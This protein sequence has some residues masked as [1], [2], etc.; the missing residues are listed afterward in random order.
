MHA[1]LEKLARAVSWLNDRVTPSTMQRLNRHLVLNHPLL[2]R[3]RLLWVAWWSALL[4]VVLTGVGYWMARST[5]SVWATAD[6][7]RLLGFI[8]YT[9][10]V[11]AITWAVLHLRIP[12]GELPFRRHAGTAV[13]NFLVILLM[14]LPAHALRVAASHGGTHLLTVGEVMEL[15][16]YFAKLE[17]CQSTDETGRQITSTLHRLGLRQR[18]PVERCAKLEVWAAS[19]PLFRHD[20]PEQYVEVP[21]LH[22]SLDPRLRGMVASSSLWHPG[23]EALHEG[24]V[25]PWR[26]ELL[27]AFCAALLLGILG[28]PVSAWRRRIGISVRL[29]GTLAMPM[30]R[31]AW[32]DRL[33]QR[34]LTSSPLIWAARLHYLLPLVASCLAVAVAVNVI[35]QLLAPREDWTITKGAAG[36]AVVC[37]PLAWQLARRT[38]IRQ[39]LPARWQAVMATSLAS[40]LCVPLLM[41]PTI[42]V[43]AETEVPRLLGGWGGGFG[44]WTAG[45]LLVR[46]YKTRFQT[47]LFEAV[48]FFVAGILAV[49]AANNVEVA[50][51]VA[52]AF[53]VAGVAFWLTERARRQPTARTRWR[54]RI[55]AMCILMFPALLIALP[56]T[57]EVPDRL[58]TLFNAYP[59]VTCGLLT[60]FLYLL[61]LRPFVRTLALA[62]L[63]P[64]AE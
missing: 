57:V 10:I 22:W 12:V 24:C 21:D 51:W 38:D 7:L 61:A 41:V 26:F 54:P 4:S 9:S 14:F 16:Q 47:F 36:V 46:A 50:R 62:E 27:L 60:P 11:L 59:L 19:G 43:V 44:V 2:W 5:S 37:W 42:A 34:L 30:P 33:D 6:L 39:V 49:I 58:V 23:T 35:G 3:S 28:Y 48:A 29:G 55:A 20:A 31:I 1:R 13:A 52:A 40:A 64:K 18:A 8:R 15:R 32:L 56:S 63:A 53:A 25:S 17:R 45:N